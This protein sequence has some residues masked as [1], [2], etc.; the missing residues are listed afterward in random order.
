[1]TGQLTRFSETYKDGSYI[2]FDGEGTGIYL[3]DNQNLDFSIF[4]IGQNF[5]DNDNFNIDL[6]AQIYND[7]VIASGAG[8]DTLILKGGGGRLSANAGAGNDTISLGDRG[9]VVDG[10]DGLDRIVYSAPLD[11]FTIKKTSQTVS[12]NDVTGS[13]LL[14][15]MEHLQFSDVTINLTIQAAAASIAAAQVTRLEELYVAFFNRIPD[16]DG[17]EYWI[18]QHK[19]GL[20]INQIAEAFYNA[21]VFY[22][23]LTGFSSSMSNAD[24]VN[25]VYRNVLGRSEGADADG[26]A[27]WS[28]ALARGEATHGSLV[29]AILDSAHTFKGNATWGWVA[30]L[31]DNKIEVAK[32]VAVDWGL[33]YNTPED[34][35]SNGMAIAAAV[36]PSDISE[37]IS[38]VGITPEHLSLI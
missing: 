35:I 34:S 37:A 16:A 25:V 36:T 33:N 19:S 38:L 32:Q 18:N 15:N 6:P 2:Q 14:S 1:M 20:S 22:A 12:V 30:D 13:D 24:F 9:H 27:F 29:S 8:D 31:L 5:P 11:G 21:G 3:A 28:G 17:M 23:D 4:T 7:V 26:L 10:G